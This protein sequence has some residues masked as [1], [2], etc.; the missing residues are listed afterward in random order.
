M[1]FL[2]WDLIV[3]YVENMES[4][5]DNGGGVNEKKFG[6]FEEFRRFG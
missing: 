5:N 6:K 1:F 3:D 4:S 2:E